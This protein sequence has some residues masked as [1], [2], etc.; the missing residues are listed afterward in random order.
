MSE[1]EESQSSPSAASAEIYVPIDIDSSD[2]SS[3][4]GSAEELPAPRHSYLPGVQHPI[5]P[6]Q[7]LRRGNATTGK[8]RSHQSI[9]DTDINMHN[10][11]IEIPILQLD[12][13]VL[14]PNCTLPLRITNPSFVKYLTRAIENARNGNNLQVRIG[15]V[16]RLAERRRTDFRSARREEDADGNR[17]D[18][19]QTRRRMGRWNM[20][21]IRRNDIPTRQSDDDEH[22]SNSSTSDEDDASGEEQESSSNHRHRRS[23]PEERSINYG[24]SLPKDRLVGR[25]G[26]IATITSVN[27]DES[28]ESGNE[29]GDGNQRSHIIVTAMTT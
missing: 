2:E 20:A 6:V 29:S 14:F 15:I 1:N 18:E 12:G 19:V 13:V 8:R 21:L 25:I 23:N 26:T 27:E 10:P 11:T 3:S 28:T 4:E 24:R 7:F 17:E 9:D 5:Y 16:T 22:D